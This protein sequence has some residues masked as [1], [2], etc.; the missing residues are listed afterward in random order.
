MKRSILAASVALVLAAV[1][2]VAVLVYVG[3]ADERALSGQKA[4]RVLVARKQIPA[5]TTG[6][7]IKSGGY[8]EVVTVPAATVPADALGDIDASLAALAVTA[9]LQPRQLLLRGA[10]DVP[11]VHNGGLPIPDGMLAVSVSVR[12]PAQVAGY[13]RPGSTVAV[14]DT[15]AVAEGKGSGGPVPSGDGLATAHDYN[16]ATRLLLPKVQIL[17]IGG[18]G[19]PGA[20][21]GPQPA[22]S[23]SATS[24]SG[25]TSGGQSGD[26]TTVLVTVAVT[27][28][29]AQRLV[30][31]AQTGALYMALLGNGTE[32]KPGPGVD[33]YSLFQ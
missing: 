5:G 8:T 27:Q 23:A 20:Q 9:D 10:F 18:R 4:V 28:D 32:A 14:F 1:G 26:T 7:A 17:A 2:C 31:V 25:A 15:Y 19:T 21:V 12:T 29:Q 16:Q 3:A 13:V 11:S 33:N 30:H 6:Q 24:G 22:P